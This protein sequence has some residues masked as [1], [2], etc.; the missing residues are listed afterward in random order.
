MAIKSVQNTSTH[1]RKKT[2]H[3]YLRNMPS[4]KRWHSPIDFNNIFLVVTKDNNIFELHGLLEHNDFASKFATRITH[5][6]F[7]YIQLT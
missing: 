1:N 4:K 7:I 6:M 3:D 2:N 5:A